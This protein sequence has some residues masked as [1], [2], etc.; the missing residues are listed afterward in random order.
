MEQHERNHVVTVMV[1][2]HRDVREQ[3]LDENILPLR[4]NSQE[5]R[6][7]SARRVV[8]WQD[9]NVQGARTKKRS[10]ESPWRV[11]TGQPVHEEEG[12][13]AEASL[14]NRSCL[15]MLVIAIVRSLVAC[16]SGPPSTNAKKPV[17]ARG[18]RTAGGTEEFD[19]STTTAELTAGAGRGVPPAA[20][21]SPVVLEVEGEDEGTEACFVEVDV[22]DAVGVGEGVDHSQVLHA[23]LARRRHVGNF[24]HLGVA[25][26]Y[27]HQL[28]AE[29]ARQPLQHFGHVAERSCRGAAGP[30]GAG[31]RMRQPRGEDS[32]EARRQV[33]DAH[34]FNSTGRRDLVRIP[35]QAREDVLVERLTLEDRVG[36]LLQDEGGRVVHGKRSHGEGSR[37]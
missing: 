13:E 1:K 34:L 26:C 22:Q 15:V 6:D 4:H 29:P 17:S 7:C 35:A 37:T 16:W 19:S 11:R 8:D 9:D 33:S 23:D 27:I 36:A 3:T 24:R 28:S 5:R 12:L 20:C 14:R 25:P 18:G 30:E 21:C 10:A 32:V 31:G 2:T